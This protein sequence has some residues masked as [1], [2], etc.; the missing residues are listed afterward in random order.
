MNRAFVI[1]VLIL[2]IFIGREL[3]RRNWSKNQFLK[4]TMQITSVAFEGNQAIP[5]EYTCDGADVNPELNITGVPSGAKSFALIMDDPDSP[6]GTF[7]HWLVWNLEPSAMAIKKSSKPDGLEGTNAVGKIGY[8]GPCPGKG[9][10]HY[11]FKLFALDALIMADQGAKRDVLEA[12]M[13]G[14]VIETAELIGTYER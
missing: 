2:A 3:L 10:H 7:T 6:Q 1:I 5:K 11:H 9:M 14:H 13:N 4:N 8:T 12:A